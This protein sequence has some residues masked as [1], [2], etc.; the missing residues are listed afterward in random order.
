MSKKFG[1]LF[2]AVGA[3][4]II[5]ALSLL[6]YNQ[7]EDAEVGAGTESLLQEVQSV[8]VQN[9]VQDTGQGTGQV[10]AEDTEPEETGENLTTFINGYE[11]L[12]VISIPTL[13]LVLPI[14]QDWSYSN[15]NLAP[16]RHFG[17]IAEDNLVIAAH[18]YTSHFGKLSKLVVG[19]TLSITDMSGQEYFYTVAM[20]KTMEATAVEEV[21]N[22]GYDLVLYTCTIS[23]QG[24]Q[25]V[26]CNRVSEP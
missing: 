17:S 22:S 1:I 25:G 11:Y 24:R 13:E 5:L 26:F 23:G 8:I 7:D 12:G 16:C 19:D 20:M 15:L 18:N 10:Q 3:V 14:L 2:F 9:Q 6:W 21:Q 4:L